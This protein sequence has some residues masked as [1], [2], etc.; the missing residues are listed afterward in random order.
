MVAPQVDGT[1]SRA[2]LTPEGRNE[3]VRFAQS[4]LGR[5]RLP[6]VDA[7]DVVQE[8]LLRMVDR[9][10]IASGAGE[11]A[12]ARPGPQAATMLI[13]HPAAYLRRAVANECVSR[14]RRLHRELLTGELP[15]QRSEDHAEQRA[16]WISVAAA[17]G[18]LTLRQQQIVA[19]GFLLDHSDTQIAADLG[20]SPITVRTMRRRALA[21]LRALLGQPPLPP[22]GALRATA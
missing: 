14:W 4:R 1:I 2:G 6:G 16:G 5:T 22:Q 10:A 13:E 9:G 3:L 11:P 17:L 18:Q 15:E 19:R 8:V 12:S 7:E 21:Q 20:I